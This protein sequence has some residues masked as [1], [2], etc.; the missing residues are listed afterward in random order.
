VGDFNGD[1]NLDLAVGDA[2]SNTV[3]I[4]LG[5]GTGNFTLAFSLS[6]GSGPQ[7]VAVGDFNGDGKLDLAV[8]TDTGLSFFLGDGTGNFSLASSAVEGQVVSVAMGDF[9]GDGKLDV[10]AVEINSNVVAIL[11]GDGTGNFTL[12]SSPATGTQPR[13]VAV[14]DFNGDGK[15]DLAVAN[16]ESGTVSILLGDGTGNFTLGSSPPAGEAVSVVVGDF[17]GD[18]KLDLAL[19]T[20]NTVSILLGNGNDNFTLALPLTSIFI[21]TGLAAGDFNGDGK[22]DLAAL[23]PNDN[24]VSILLQAPVVTLSPSTLTFGNQIVGASSAPQTAILSNVGY[25]TVSISGI[26]ISGLDSEDFAETNNCGASLA[27]AASCTIT[28]TFSPVSGDTRTAT[29]DCFHFRQ[30]R[31]QS[32]DDFINGNRAC[33][34][35]FRHEPEFRESNGGQDQPAAD[36]GVD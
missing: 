2:N 28:I 15:L 24:E 32:S 22:L 10:A 21:P 34:R 23:N 29:R 30:R 19:S 13:S 31:Q 36:C 6:T 1:G 11:L 27:V 12:A 4:L 26:T 33:G 7:A 35:A 14:S 18:G 16:G 25:A 9:N 5:D 8:G 3:S 20:S 17:N